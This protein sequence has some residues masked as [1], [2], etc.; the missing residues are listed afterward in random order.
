M[1]NITLPDGSVRQYE[2][3]VTVA[4]IAESIGAG[5]AKATVAGKVNGALVDACDPI[6]QDS[7]VQII[8]PK[9]QEGV[10]IIRHS[11]AHLVGHAVKQLFPTAKM[12]IGPVIEEG[13]YYDILPEKPFT[14]EDMA[15]IEERMKQ[16]IN[17]DYDVIKKMTPRAEVVEIFKSRGEEYKL[18]LIDDMD[19]SIQA[20][21]MYFHQEYVDM[22]R[23]PHVPNTRFLKHFKLTKMSGAYWRGD[24]N[25][26]QLQRIY[27]TAW[28][29]KDELKAYITR[30][31]E[32]EKRDHRKLG[33]QLDLFHLQDEAPGMVFWHPRGWALWQVIEQ[34][35]RRELTEAG[36]QEVKTPQVMD[37]T[38][39]EKSGHWANYKDNMF[40]TSSEKRE[41]AV[42]PMNCPGHVQIFNHGLRSYRDLPMRLAEFG[43][44][45]RNEP[46]GA[47]HGLMRVRGFVQDDAH[48]FCT[49]DQ[50]AEET[51]KFNLLVMKIYQQFGFK[52]VSIKLSLR[53]EKRAG[54][55]EIWDKA[56]QGLRDALTACGVE[57]EELPG[58]GAFYGPKV[59]YHIKDALGRSWQCGTIQLDFVLPERLEAEYVA[60][61]NT[62]KRPVMLHRAILGS[63]ERFIGILIE[64]HAGSFPLWLA[65]VQMVVMNI[66]EKQADYAKEVQA[67]LQAAGFRVDLDIRNEKIGYKIRSNSEMRYPYQLTVGDKEMENGQVSIRKK[68]DNLGSVSVDEFIAMLQDELKQAVE[69]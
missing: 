8:T 11:C 45:H 29:N 63:L 12:V 28:A 62:K 1:L 53:P 47:L 20:M 69:V 18:R 57:W 68:A 14:P 51:K 15:A 43:S 64:E 38:F 60:E 17:Q 52:N 39:W 58:E 10:E 35:M 56:E 36:Y 26:E 55:E 3:P 46:S 65:P 34:H 54:S 44:C 32:A 59:E 49:E 41:Y 50:I 37:K 33:K 21:G 19:D 27:G 67:K 22:C 23:G 5:L 24:S 9:D 13:F 6:T 61:D 4:Q 40:L 48:I 66:T 42:K 31:E 2:S 30:I 7:T 16:L 25:N